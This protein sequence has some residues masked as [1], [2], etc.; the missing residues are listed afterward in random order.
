MDELCGVKGPALARGVNETIE[1]HVAR[2]TQRAIDRWKSS[3]AA[4]GD[5]QSQ[6]IGLALMN[7]EPAGQVI[8]SDEVAAGIEP[9][10]DNPPNNNL[11]LLAVQMRDPAIYSLAMGQCSG[12]ILGDMASGSCQGLSFEQWASIDPDNGLPWLWIATKAAGAGDQQG[13]DEG[14]TKAAA[15]PR[16]DSYSAELSALA[17]GALPGDVAP[18]EKAVAGADVMN[19]ARMGVPVALISL[20]SADAIEQPLRKQQCS[21]IARTL[22]SQ[23]STY[24]ALALASGMANR[25]G[26]PE[27]VRATLKA[28]LRSS[29]TVLGNYPWGKSD[30]STA[31]RCDTVLA[32]DDFVDA[33]RTAG[34][35]ER[36][37]LRAL[38]A[39]RERAD[40]SSASG[41]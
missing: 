41:R 38:A 27:D 8:N 9:S 5:P 30:A 36:A 7:A 15:A 19:T 35:K 20:C 12:P 37:A 40:R 3:L 10:K 25:L 22:A 32:Y 17:L 16:I 39:A 28:E 26:F 11:V 2:L 13:V 31:F 1:E 23:G 29:R 21:A 24:I 34:G 4:S 18:L 6:A 33:L 14:L